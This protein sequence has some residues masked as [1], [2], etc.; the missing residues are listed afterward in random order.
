[1]A[2]L[3]RAVH[4]QKSPSEHFAG[5]ML[6]NPANSD[7]AMRPEQT[8]A[9][10]AARDA[11][12]VARSPESTAADRTATPGVGGR[13]PASRTDPSGV[14]GAYRDILQFAGSD[15]LLRV[16]LIAP[17]WQRLETGRM[18]LLQAGRLLLEISSLGAGSSSDAKTHICIALQPEECAQLLLMDPEVGLWPGY[19]R[20]GP[21]PEGLPRWPAPIPSKPGR[22]WSGTK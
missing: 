18:K 11:A 6:S 19:G 14:G 2:M 16:R 9:G 13:G 4:A 8:T 22:A 5:S 1:M 17:R 21:T 10:M 20:T 3:E 12:Q 7:E 15:A